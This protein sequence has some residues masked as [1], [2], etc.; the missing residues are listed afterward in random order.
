MSKYTQLH[1]RC[2]KLDNLP[3]LSLKAGYGIH[4]HIEGQENIWEDIIEQAFGQHFSFKD[5]LIPAGNYAPEYV[6]YVTKDGKEISTAMGT[7]HANF[8]NE[9]W[10]RMIAALPEARGTGA[11]KLACLAVMHSLKA[12]GYNSIVLSTDDYRLPAISMYLSLGFEPI[13]FDEEH[14]ERWNKVLTQIKQYKAAK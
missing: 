9:G 4:T 13:I 14:K 3:S 11:G 10:F 2:P 1:M 8:P 5:F 7:E 12:R 6:Y